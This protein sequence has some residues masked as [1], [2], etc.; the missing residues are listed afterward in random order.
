[1]KWWPISIRRFFCKFKKSQK[2][3]SNSDSQIHIKGTRVWIQELQNICEKNYNSP[4]EG[5]RLIRE[6]QIEWKDAAERKELNLELI[7]GL[8]RRAFYLLKANEEEWIELLDNLNFWRPGW[9]VD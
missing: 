5:K 7:E 9:K 8:D 6:M 4:H 3:K 2:L 1:M